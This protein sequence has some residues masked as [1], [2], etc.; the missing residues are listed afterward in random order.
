MLHF[1]PFFPN[2]CIHIKKSLNR[3]YN[4]TNRPVSPSVLKKEENA[5]TSLKL[6][7]SNIQ[8]FRT[9]NKKTR[10][11]KYTSATASLGVGQLQMLI[12]ETHSC[13][14]E[15]SVTIEMTIGS[16]NR[17]MILISP[18]DT[19]RNSM[20]FFKLD[21]LEGYYTHYYYFAEP[22]DRSREDA[23]V[24][25]AEKAER[26]RRLE[27]ERERKKGGKKKKKKKDHALIAAVTLPAD[28]SA[29]FAVEPGK[30]HNNE[31]T[32]DHSVLEETENTDTLDEA[33][34]STT[35][36]DKPKFH[37]ASNITKY[38]WRLKV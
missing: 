1:F 2:R 17:D 28:I 37:I 12:E 6:C 22:I 7:F 3:L 4:T 11:R 10:R 9:A 30:Q 18:E 25:A 29:T 16:I 5:T 33:R 14:L 20:S 35:V 38:I 27:E 24:I 34:L 19:E 8:L 26:L 32:M 21:L 31:G 15:Y 36:E 23:A 13:Y